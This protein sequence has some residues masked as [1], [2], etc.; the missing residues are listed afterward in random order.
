MIDTMFDFFVTPSD[1]SPPGSP[2]AFRGLVGIW[3]WEDFEDPPQRFMP[4]LV[5]EFLHGVLCI[6][7]VF[8]MVRGND[9][10][11]PLQRGLRLVFQNI[12]SAMPLGECGV[13][14]LNR[15]L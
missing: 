3:H 6:L 13:V 4:Q 5:G 10:D 11:S 7:R 1:D 15:G 9:R 14:E 2:F 12:G 8:V